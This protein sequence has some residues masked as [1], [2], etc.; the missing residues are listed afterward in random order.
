MDSKSK[1]TKKLC[2]ALHA[3]DP[4]YKAASNVEF[5]L[6]LAGLVIAMLIVRMFVVEPVR[7]EGPSMMNTLQ[8]GE[9]C[10]VEKISFLFSKPKTGDIVIVHFPGMGSQAYVKRVIATEGQTIQLGTDSVV[11]PKTG[12]AKKRF[13]VL[14]DGVELDESLYADT[15][16]YDEGRPNIEINSPGSSFGRYTVPEGCVFVMGDHRT[17]SH[18]S[19]ASDVGAIPLYDVIGRVRGV[20]F[21]FGGMRLVH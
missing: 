10:L 1:N 18:D 7:V 4:G 11:D 9:R 6:F 2:E 14:V 17:N 16:L 19:R 21:P 13:F 5:I 3:K 20:V 12:E 15:M 8:D